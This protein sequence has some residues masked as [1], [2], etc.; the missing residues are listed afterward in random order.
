MDELSAVHL[1]ESQKDAVLTLLQVID[2]PRVQ[3][4]GF[5]V[6]KV[7]RKSAAFSGIGDDTR[8]RIEKKLFARREEILKLRGELIPTNLLE[9][10]G[11]ENQWSLTLHPDNLQVMETVG[12][13][14]DLVIRGEHDHFIGRPMASTK[15]QISFDIFAGVLEE[16]KALLDM[17]EL[18][19]RSLG[20]HLRMPQLSVSVPIS[21]NL[22]EGKAELWSMKAI[23]CSLKF[24]TQGLDALRAI[25]E[26]LTVSSDETEQSQ[27]KLRI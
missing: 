13:G 12:D 20:K 2:D 11:H 27:E 24:G 26:M 3:N 19:A 21:C 10:L 17:I 15:A 8:S 4:I 6:A 9:F 1:S 22:H 25:S 18:H 5:D 14:W 7:I 23:L 16:S